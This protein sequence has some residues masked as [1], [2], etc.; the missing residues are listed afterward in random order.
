MFLWFAFE[1][2]R[3]IDRKKER[4]KEG[5]PEKATE[6]MFILPTARS[7]SPSSWFRSSALLLWFFVALL[8]EP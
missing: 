6:S 8:R 3:E 4:E 2:E 7:P 1:I 5:G